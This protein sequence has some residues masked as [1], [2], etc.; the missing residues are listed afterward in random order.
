VIDFRDPWVTNPFR[1]LPNN[2][3]LGNYDRFLEKKVIL[4]GDRIVCATPLMAKDLIERYSGIEGKISFVLNGYDPLLFSEDGHVAHLDRERVKLTHVGS[5]YGKR[6]ITFLL[7]ALS[8]LKKENPDIA[9][10]F[11]FEFIGP[12]TAPYREIIEEMELSDM[13]RLYGP[14]SYDTAL[15]KYRQATVC[16]CVGVSGTK[17]EFQIPA[18]LYEFISFGKPVFALASAASNIAL[19]LKDAG[20]QYFLADPSK[21]LEIY[22][23]LKEL[24]SKWKDGK[25]VYGGNREKRMSFDSGMMAEKLEDIFLEVSSKG[26]KQS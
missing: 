26:N 22:S 24:H 6:D 8:I 5:L 21:P 16:I 17:I 12:G 2:L 7:R 1:E 9:K 20:V 3:L 18:K 23:R 25:L 11:C 19:I 14:I 15:D 13:L 4:L 10:D